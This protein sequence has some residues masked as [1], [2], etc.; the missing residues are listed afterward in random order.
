VQELDTGQ[1]SAEIKPDTHGPKI[2]TKKTAAGGVLKIEACCAAA[3]LW[4][5]EPS[6]ARKTLV[7]SRHVD[8]KKNGKHQICTGTPVPK[9][10]MSGRIRDLNTN[11]PKYEREITSK[12]TSPSN[13]K[14]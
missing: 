10:K 2:W 12:K 5:A 6:A 13:R 14:M 11:L 8:Q 3:R 4:P 7:G 1:T 9:S